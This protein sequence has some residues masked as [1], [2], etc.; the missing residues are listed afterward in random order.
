MWQVLYYESENGKC[1]VGEFLESLPL[2][3]K[4]KAYR[5]ISLLEKL[6][7]DIKMPFSRPMGNGINEL[8]IQLGNDISRVFYFFFVDQS[9]ILTNGYIKKTQQTPRKE[10]ERAIMYKNDY[11]R[12]NKK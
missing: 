8:R 3:I 7:V 2:K 12:R 6:G 11:V 1:P 4:K 5:D 9:I 10:L